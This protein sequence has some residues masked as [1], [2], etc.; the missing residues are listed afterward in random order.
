MKHL[1]NIPIVTHLIL[2]KGVASQRKNCTILEII[3]IDI[4]QRIRGQT[5]GNIPS[6]AERRDGEEV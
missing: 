6:S 3:E 1:I 4:G 5:I 2:V